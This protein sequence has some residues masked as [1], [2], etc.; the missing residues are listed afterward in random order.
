MLTEQ[1]KLYNLLHIEHL[2]ASGMTA[3]VYLATLESKE[4]VIK[5][6]KSTDYEKYF[7]KE[8][9]FIK[10]MRKS[11]NVINVFGFGKVM[12]PEDRFYQ[13]NYIIMEYAPKGDLVSIIEEKK[14]LKEAEIK[15]VLLS[16][17]NGL[18]DIHKAGF[19]HRDLKPENILINCSN[20]YLITDFGFVDEINQISFERKGTEGYISPEVLQKRYI[21][22]PEAIDVFSLGVIVYILT[23]GE[24]PFINADREDNLYKYIISNDWDTYWRKVNKNYLSNSLK[25]LLQH[26]MCAEPEKR[27]SLMELKDHSW[28]IN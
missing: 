3:N 15:G 23:T 8:V 27:Y 24:F 19:I 14:Q 9:A 16:I 17:M 4:V 26:T 11:R 28:F 6:F 10:K 13:K 21:T 2:F 18:S 7:N 12:N 5:I 25:D 1:D 20:D 22:H